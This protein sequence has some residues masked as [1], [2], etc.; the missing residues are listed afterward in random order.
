MDQESI[1]FCA[2]YGVV[3][4]NKPVSDPSSDIFLIRHGFSE[5]NY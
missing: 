2:K 1:D 4:E 3:L 5:F